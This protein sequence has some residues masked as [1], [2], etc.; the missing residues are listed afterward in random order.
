MDVLR[1][2]LDAHWKRELP[3]V[4]GDTEHYRTEVCGC[5]W[6]GRSGT[7]ADHREQAIRA[8]LAATPPA[9]APKPSLAAAIRGW[10]YREDATPPASAE[11]DA[12]VEADMDTIND[13]CLLLRTAGDP[14]SLGVAERLSELGDRVY[15]AALAATPPASAELREAAQAFV[16]ATEDPR[17]WA[18]LI[19]DGTSPVRFVLSG[20][21]ID[22]MRDARNAV[23]AALAATPPASAERDAVVEQFYPLETWA[24]TWNRQ[25]AIDV[26]NALR[27]GRE[28]ECNCGIEITLRDALRAAEARDE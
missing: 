18:V 25:H 13:A 15:A 9:S 19:A 2:A 26:A 14:V 21:L 12:V 20:A 17:I 10:S 8:A 6:E 22:T 27:E 3:Y 23:R 28:P 11:R 4:E 7:W 16:D 24:G 1:E 5:G